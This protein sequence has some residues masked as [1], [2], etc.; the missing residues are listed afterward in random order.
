MVLLIKLNHCPCKVCPKVCRG[1]FLRGITQSYKALYNFANFFATFFV[2]I[3]CAQWHIIAM[4]SLHFFLKQIIYRRKKLYACRI[5]FLE[6]LGFSGKPEKHLPT[7]NEPPQIWGSSNLT[8]LQTKKTC[9]P[10][11]RQGFV[12]CK[13]FVGTQTTAVKGYY[14][15]LNRYL[16]LYSKISALRVIV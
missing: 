5:L 12:F 2:G 10:H 14:A 16:W 4:F 15:I 3:F 8:I 1:L 13:W 7:R 11:S 6:K 9:L